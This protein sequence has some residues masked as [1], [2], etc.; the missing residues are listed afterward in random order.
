MTVLS[1]L[2]KDVVSIDT[3]YAKGEVDFQPQINS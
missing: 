2:R 3:S 1:Q